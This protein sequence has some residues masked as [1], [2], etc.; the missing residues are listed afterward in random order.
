MQNA[1]EST[2]NFLKGM[3]AAYKDEN[4]GLT[5]LDGIA[6]GLILATHRPKFAGTMIEEMSMYKEGWKGM[7]EEL[8]EVVDL[9]DD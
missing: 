5:I 2:I 6:M 7:V 8:L 4:P 9:C 3:I 1:S